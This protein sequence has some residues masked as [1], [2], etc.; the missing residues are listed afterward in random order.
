MNVFDILSVVVG[1][2]I[3]VGG[4]GAAIHFATTPNPTPTEYEY[5]VTS[6]QVQTNAGYSD[7]ATNIENLPP[8]LQS[9]LVDSFKK[10]DGFFSSESVSITTEKR[11]PVETAG[12]RT[13]SVD[14]VV[15]LVTVEE[16]VHKTDFIGEALFQGLFFGLSV[17][18]AVC[19][20]ALIL[21]GCKGIRIQN[22]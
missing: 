18:I 11:L 9:L 2:L 22:S 17:A 14:G 12:F 13:V 19:A 21:E 7:D 3:L 8:E 10:A 20:V 6:E 15:L 16:E 5:T 1:V 4:V